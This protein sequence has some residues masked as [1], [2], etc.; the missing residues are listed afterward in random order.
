MINAQ[1][2]GPDAKQ[3]VTSTR[4]RL[5]GR[6]ALRLGTAFLTLM[7]QGRRR[8]ASEAGSRGVTASGDSAA[9]QREVCVPLV[10]SL[11]QERRAS[12]ESSPEKCC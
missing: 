10:R 1:T 7:L 5:P 11:L 9:A 8:H 4:L 3:P 2:K 12:P 6:R